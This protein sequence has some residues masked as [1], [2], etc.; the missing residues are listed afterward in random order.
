MGFSVLEKTSDGGEYV[1]NTDKFKQLYLEFQKEV[2][3]QEKKKKGD[4]QKELAELLSVDV[5]TI[6]GWR[7]ARHAPHDIKIVQNLAKIWGLDD[8][9]VL[10]RECRKGENKDVKK[11]EYEMRAARKIYAYFVDTIEQYYG[12]YVNRFEVNKDIDQDSVVIPDSLDG[13]P[14]DLYYQSIVFLRKMELDIPEE[15]MDRIHG[16]VHYLFP[17]KDMSYYYF[18]TDEDGEDEGRYGRDYR[19][20]KEYLQNNPWYRDKITIAQLG[21]VMGQKEKAYA[22]LKELFKDYLGYSQND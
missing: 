18:P 17:M 21:F 19:E 14:D 8:Y 5:S 7:Y 11:S 3:K 9:H 22:K 10:L 12:I 16:F 20:Y 6:K 2:I 13:E 4:F 15:M 1:F